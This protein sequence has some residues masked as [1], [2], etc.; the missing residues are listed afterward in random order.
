MRE[1]GIIRKIDELGRIVIPKE[2]RKT[3]K[4]D[5]GEPM[6][7][8]T[9]DGGEIIFKKYSPIEGYSAIAEYC[10]KSL[11][12]SLD[13]PV[14]ITDR[15]QIVSVF[16]YPKSSLEGKAI[17]KHLESAM[18]RKKIFALG[19]GEEG[20]DVSRGSE[21][22]A[23]IIAPVVSNGK[24]IGCVVVLDSSARSRNVD[25]TEVKLCSFACSFLS[26][27]TDIK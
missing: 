14:A 9:G 13:C 11:S 5:V 21:Q 2:L 20:A 15:E 25:A 1:T 7:I 27:S 3:Y 12:K 10:A 18:E 26:E 6:Q 4:I 22:K 17:S 24:S 16:G 8:Y 23:R 19:D